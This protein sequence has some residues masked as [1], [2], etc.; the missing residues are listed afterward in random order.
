MDKI[1]VRYDLLDNNL[2]LK[3]AQESINEMIDSIDGEL[4]Y[5]LD[6]LGDSDIILG[7]EINGGTDNYLIDNEETVFVLNGRDLENLKAGK[8]VE[9]QDI[10]KIEEVMDSSID[11]HIDFLNWFK[12]M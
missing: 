12:G 10:G 2:I 11:S 7:N 8:E 5:L 1:T 3:L 6:L 9:L 4:N